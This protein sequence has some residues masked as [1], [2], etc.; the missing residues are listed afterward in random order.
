M[1]LF[2][3]F[4]GVLHPWKHA[5]EGRFCRLPLLEAWLRQRPG[6]EVVI[7]SSWKEIHPFEDELRDLFSS[8]LRGRILGCTPNYD[9]M[10]GTSTWE[11]LDRERDVSL[12]KRE[13]EC[14]RWLHDAGRS[15]E[16][17]AALD[18]MPE[19]FRPGT[20]ELIA[21]DPNTGVTVQKLRELDRL[22]G[23]DE[24]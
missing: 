8:D 18:D 12:Y 17:W 3:D 21:C 1:V 16:N 19:L 11:Q 6:V 5:P 4:D 15:C 14:R 22:L 9:K 13:A 23:W 2:L 7:S 20:R 10:L 24:P